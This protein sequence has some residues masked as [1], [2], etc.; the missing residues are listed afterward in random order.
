M[1]EAAT[2]GVDDASGD[3][4][5]KAPA[6][7]SVEEILATDAE[8]ESLRRYKANLLG[9]GNI[10]I[11]PNNRKNVLVRSLTLMVADRPD[12]TMDLSTAKDLSGQTFVIKE[13]CEY[14]LRIDFHV[15]REIVAGLKYVQKVYRAGIQVDK[16]EFMVGSYPP[17]AD[18]QSY[19]T[20]VD[21]APKG[22]MHRGKYKV[23]SLFTDDDKDD[24]LSWEWNLDIKKDWKDGDD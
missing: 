23:K 17:K 1:A 12:I 24:W 20:P 5:Y 11:E 13:G 9:G 19:T 15:Q 22:L 16:D 3:S 8:D 7:R 18:L 14:R 10:V 6:K 4:N 21:E 2:I